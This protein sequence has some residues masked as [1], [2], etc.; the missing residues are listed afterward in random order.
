M[1]KSLGLRTDGVTI[2]PDKVVNLGDD[3]DDDDEDNDVMVMV[4]WCFTSLSTLF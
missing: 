4:T 1:A 3:D 2:S